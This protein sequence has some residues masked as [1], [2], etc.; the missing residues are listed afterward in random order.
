MIAEQTGATARDRNK[1]ASNSV[2]SRDGATI[3]YLSIGEGPGVVVIPGALSVATDYAEFAD[4]LAERYTV[5]IIERRGRGLSDPQGTDY[6]MDKERDD[7]LALMEKTRARFVVGH[8]FGGLVALETARGNPAIVKVAVYEPGVSIAG[9]ISMDWMAEYEKKLIEKKE[10][11]AFVV[12]SLGTGPERA[13]KTPHWLM[14]LLLPRFI[15]REEMR[16]MMRLLWQN[17]REHREVERLDSK[18]ENYREIDAEVSL[19]SGGKSRIGWVE[20]ALKELTQVISRSEW[21][22][23]PGLDHF[24]IDKKAPQEIARVV[25]DYFAG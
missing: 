16:T 7:V 5:H 13:R 14:K 17:L 4:A 18:V 24:G 9:S 22:V 21:K 2:I 12:F 10:F 1:I 11:D 19:M 6:G 25:G 15:S 8:S 3:G 20:L 23:F